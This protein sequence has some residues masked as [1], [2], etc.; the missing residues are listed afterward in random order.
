MRITRPLATGITGPE[1]PA[2]GTAVSKMLT[3]GGDAGS[4]HGGTGRTSAVAGSLDGVLA[5]GLTPGDRSSGI[6]GAIAR[7]CDAATT[8]TGMAR[9]GASS[10]A[11]RPPT[12]CQ[13]A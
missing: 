8:T 1:P 9:D 11:A 5:L 2:T 10:G 12:I 3:R 7:R 4:G 6:G 13:E